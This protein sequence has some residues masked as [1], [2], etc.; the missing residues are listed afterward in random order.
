[1]I[2]RPGPFVRTRAIAGVVWVGMW[3]YG[4]TVVARELTKLAW[5]RWAP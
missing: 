1:M 3:V 2:G 5:R 4:M